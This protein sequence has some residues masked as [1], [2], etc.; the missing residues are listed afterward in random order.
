MKDASIPSVLC[1]AHSEIQT[2]T[3]EGEEE[4]EEQPPQ[5][6]TAINNHDFK[7]NDDDDDDDAIVDAVVSSGSYYSSK[8]FPSLSS[9]AMY[10]AAIH[11][12]PRIAL[13]AYTHSR[14]KLHQ[15]QP[16]SIRG[17]GQTLVS[18][19][20]AGPKILLLGG[21]T[22][23]TF[24]GLGLWQLGRL[25]EDWNVA[26]DRYQQLQL[27]PLNYGN[28]HSGAIRESLI[29][30]ELQQQ[31]QPL[32]DGVVVGVE[33]VTNKSNKNNNSNKNTALQQQKEMLQQLPYR[34]RWIRGRFRHDKEVLIGPRVAPPG[35]PTKSE[36]AQG[37]CVLTP[38]EVER[39]A[40]ES[41]N[42]TNNYPPNVVVW[43]NR[44]WIPKTLLPK[45]TD[46]PHYYEP[47][48]A[49]VDKLLRERPSAWY[50]PDGIVE[51]TAIPSK[52]ESECGSR[53]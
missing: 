19:S 32:H 37:F 49:R 13:Y 51:L 34:R 4:E 9:I 39:K 38:L 30:Q 22:C 23:S 40:N 50:R 52:T 35:V 47:R 33:D 41:V 53:V 5:I 10:C 6:A 46:R 31:Q 18:F 11:S 26:D 14:D 42:T 12:I 16:Q 3:I 1:T 44:G 8:D 29:S 45:W 17:W 43:I 36:G 27:E 28:F 24:F 15:Q 25:S 7:D 2:M 20:A 48:I 21:A